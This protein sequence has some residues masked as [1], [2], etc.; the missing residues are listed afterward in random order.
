LHFEAGT[1][2]AAILQAHGKP[3]HI[4]ANG[5]RDLYDGGGAIQIADVTGVAE[6]IQNGLVKH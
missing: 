6:V 4:A 1:T 2:D 5:V 3:E